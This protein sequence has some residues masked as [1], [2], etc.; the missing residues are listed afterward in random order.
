VT[1]C[2]DRS[3]CKQSGAMRNADSARR[4]T[5]IVRPRASTDHPLVRDSVALV[6]IETPARSLGWRT[7]G[8][9]AAG[10]SP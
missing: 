2:Q 10:R 8:A 5:E 1:E 9:A 7:F 6:V 4:A 3:P